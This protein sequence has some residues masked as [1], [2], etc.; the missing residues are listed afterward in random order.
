K[1]WPFPFPPLFF[2]QTLLTV[3]STAH[4]TPFSETRLI[5]FVIYRPGIRFFF[6]SFA[7]H[8]V[9]CIQPP[10]EHALFLRRTSKKL[11]EQDDFSPC[12]L[13]N[14]TDPPTLLQP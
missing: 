13:S 9:E 4:S 10:T 8:K 6:Q 11:H 14:H 7:I 3:S 5:H 1:S 2:K 12:P